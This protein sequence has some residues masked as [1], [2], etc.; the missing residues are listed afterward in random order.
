MSETQV[1]IYAVPAFFAEYVSDLEQGIRIIMSLDHPS[2]DAIADAIF[3]Q[4]ACK[5]SIKA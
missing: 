2:Y 5:A 1:S 4:K 3:A